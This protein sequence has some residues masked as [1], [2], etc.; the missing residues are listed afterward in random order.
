[1]TEHFD[2]LMDFFKYAVSGEN[3]YDKTAC[4][5]RDFHYNYE[6]ELI[7][8]VNALSRKE[9]KE[10]FDY[11]MSEIDNAKS[12]IN[13]W[14]I[15]HDE[16]K[17]FS[18]NDSWSS[19]EIDSLLNLLNEMKLWI[20]KQVDPPLPQRR[21]PQAT[22]ES[23]FNN[24]NDAKEIKRLFKKEGYTDQGK[25]QHVNRKKRALINAYY[26]LLPILKQG[27]PIPHLRV[28]YAEFKLPDDYINER[29]YTRLPTNKNR[30]E[31]EKLFSKLIPEN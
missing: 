8:Y 28:F 16:I 22:F 17:P 10:A 6:H 7:N 2:N 20:I 3:P 27:E 12:A 24:P 21:K 13:W 26:V 23:L 5:R 1:M 11:Y 4:F 29:Q 9:R 19:D 31:F 18:A 30:K 25:W 14:E 15:H